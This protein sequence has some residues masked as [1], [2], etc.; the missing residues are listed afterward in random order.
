MNQRKSRTL[1]FYFVDVFAVELLTGNPA[2][3]VDGGKDETNEVLGRIAKEFNQSETTEG[4]PRARRES[5][6]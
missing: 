5:R 4:L 1:P 3:V 6:R 2:V